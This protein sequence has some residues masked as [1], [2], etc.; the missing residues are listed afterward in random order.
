MLCAVS[1]L[2][3][4]IPTPL[5][6]LQPP[7]VIASAAYVLAASA[8]GVATIEQSLVSFH[9]W[10]RH[11]G[12]GDDDVEEDEVKDEEDV[13]GQSSPPRIPC[14]CELAR[15]IMLTRSEF[16]PGLLAQNVFCGWLSAK[17]RPENSQS[18]Q[19]T[20]IGDQNHSLLLP[21]STRLSPLRITRAISSPHP[22]DSHP[23]KAALR[24]ARLPHL[25]TPPLVRPPRPPMDAT[26]TNHLLPRRRSATV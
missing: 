3:R 15:H 12:I 2:V 18:L 14:P 9:D 24:P 4:S 10:K 22:P 23:T 19:C 16:F 13:E 25:A 8:L 20:E 21:A 6:V 5:A 11:F 1:T 26:R 7:S 17:P